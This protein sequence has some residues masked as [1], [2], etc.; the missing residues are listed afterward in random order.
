MVVDF[1]MVHVNYVLLATNAIERR[2]GVGDIDSE[3]TP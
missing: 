2:E 1:I 3:I